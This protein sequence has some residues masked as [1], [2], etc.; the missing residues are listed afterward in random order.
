MDS[1]SVHFVF[2]VVTHFAAGVA[3]VD[4]TGYKAESGRHLTIADGS[5]T[6][7][8]NGF[9]VGPAALDSF[10]WNHV[11]DQIAGASFSQ[12]ATAYDRFRSEERRVGR[13]GRSR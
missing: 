13:G 2:H 4:A 8:S 7:D 5:V 6:A 9:T 3:A 10:E 11:N 1:S 12:T